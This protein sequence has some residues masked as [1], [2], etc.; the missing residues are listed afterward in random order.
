MN[1][2]HGA[3]RDPSPSGGQPRLTQDQAARLLAE[4][5]LANA[6]AGTDEANQHMVDEMCRRIALRDQ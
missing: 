2:I 3:M 4:Q 1:W 5:F 6:D